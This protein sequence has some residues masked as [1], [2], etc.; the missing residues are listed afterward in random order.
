M[1]KIFFVVFLVLG[2]CMSVSAQ[3]YKEIGDKSYLLEQAT[4]KFIL[5]VSAATWEK[6]EMF[7]THFG[8]EFDEITKIS[9]EA[10]IAGFNGNSPK[11]KID[12]TSSNPKYNIVFK[13]ANLFQRKGWGPYGRMILK[14]WGR[15]DVIDTNTLKNVYSV[16]LDGALGHADFKTTDRFSKLFMEVAKQFVVR[17]SSVKKENGL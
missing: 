1:K 11:L 15:I 14:V 13:V 9:N 8:D 16:K 17:K 7:K 2:C 4:A 6:D 12:Q 3:K 10:F 5:D